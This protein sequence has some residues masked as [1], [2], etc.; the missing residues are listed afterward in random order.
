M[1]LTTNKKDTIE[2]FYERMRRWELLHGGMQQKE[3][4]K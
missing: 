4:D 1:K 3:S 2:A